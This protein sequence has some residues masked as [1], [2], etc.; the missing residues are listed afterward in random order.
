MSRSKNDANHR[1]H[2]IRTW[3]VGQA[4]L[5]AAAGISVSSYKRWKRRVRSG[6]IRLRK[7]PGAKKVAPIDLGKL[8]QQIH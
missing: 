4:S 5:L 6:M 8:K 2:K 3:H 7:S 1:G